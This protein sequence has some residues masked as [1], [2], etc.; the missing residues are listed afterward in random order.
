MTAPLHARDG[1]RHMKNSKRR[2]FGWRNGHAARSDRYIPVPERRR[3]YLWSGNIDE[4][5]NDAKPRGS[6]GRR[7]AAQRLH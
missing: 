5:S 7:F 3:G 4:S 2:L 6:G 1:K